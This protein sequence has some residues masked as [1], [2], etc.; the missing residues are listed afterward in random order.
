M[1]IEMECSK[2][3]VANTCPRR[4]ASPLASDNK[5]VFKCRIIGGFGREPV[6]PLILSA[7]SRAIFNRN[8]PCLTIAE[9]PILDDQKTVTYEVTKIFSPPNLSAR[10][11]N[12]IITSS[13]L[14]VRSYKV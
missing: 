8:G 6:D 10:E 5:S 11:E 3:A 12:P 14:E 1:F 7:E 9:V 2:C 4:G 13:D